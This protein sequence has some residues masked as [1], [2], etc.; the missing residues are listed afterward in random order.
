MQQLFL[1]LKTHFNRFSLYLSLD[2]ASRHV[3][4]KIKT[5]YGYCT[6]SGKTV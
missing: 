6:N 3:G 5:F 2:S 1:S 4:E